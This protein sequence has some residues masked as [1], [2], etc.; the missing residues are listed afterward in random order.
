M[1]RGML[2]VPGAT[3]WAHPFDDSVM[4]PL[5]PIMA[6]IGAATQAELIELANDR[7]VAVE[8]N[9]GAALDPAY[10]EAA[11]AFFRLARAMRARFT[12]T[13]DAHHPDAFERLDSA[14]NWARAMGFRDSD[15]LTA[16][17]IR[18]RFARKWKSPAG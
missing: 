6:V 18:E 15:F 8:I 3:V 5:A 12:V 4:Q 17:E 13:A 2:S 14:M 7:E 10:R 1:A 9:G 11:E 16:D